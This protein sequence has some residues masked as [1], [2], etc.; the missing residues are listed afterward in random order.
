MDNITLIIM[1]VKK[2][3]NLKKRILSKLYNENTKIVQVS[4]YL[5][6]L[7]NIGKYFVFG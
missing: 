4:N 1:K 7:N 5:P 2:K 6:Y 3:I